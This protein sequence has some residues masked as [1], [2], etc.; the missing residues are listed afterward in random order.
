MY[1]RVKVLLPN[2]LRSRLAGNSIHWD[3][4]E[5][6]AQSSQRNL[7]RGDEGK[8]RVNLSGASM[9][10]IFEQGVY[11]WCLTRT[12]DAIGIRLRAWRL[13]FQRAPVNSVLAIP[14]PNTSTATVPRVYA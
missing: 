1:Y 3:V 13:E 6:G 14:K 9:S 11:L 4:G 8:P 10:D 7:A 2:D 5:I 12:H